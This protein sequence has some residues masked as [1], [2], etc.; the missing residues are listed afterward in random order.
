MDLFGRSKGAEEE[1][2]LI[3]KM[4]M[5]PVSVVVFSMLSK[6]PGERKRAEF[7]LTLRNGCL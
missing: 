7:W 4:P 3:E 1:F 2:G 5:S 6:G